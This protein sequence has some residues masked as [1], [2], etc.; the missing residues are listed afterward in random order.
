MIKQTFII[1]LFLLL[2]G[3][4]SCKDD[5]NSKEVRA[6]NVHFGVTASNIFVDFSSRPNDDFIMSKEGWKLS[7]QTFIYDNYGTL[8][9]SADI[10]CSNLTD[11]LFFSPTLQPGEYL[12]LSVADF[13]EGLG[14]QGYRF[15]YISNEDKLQ[16]MVISESSEIYPVA[17]ETLGLE[18]QK[19]TVNKD[20]EVTVNASIKPFTS[21][22]RIH[23]SNSDISG[24][25][26][27]GYSRFTTIV[28]KYN[29]FMSNPKKSVC[30]QDGFFKVVNDDSI[31]EEIICTSEVQSTWLDRLEPNKHTYRALLPNNECLFSWNIKQEEL[32]ADDVLSQFAGKIFTSGECKNKITI[33]SNKQYEMDMILDILELN[34]TE[35]TEHF[36]FEAYHNELI[37]Q[38]YKKSIDEFLCK[39][40]EDLLLCSE[41][42]V[43]DFFNMFP[44][45]WEWT[46]SN[47]LYMAHYPRPGIESFE[48]E[49]TACYSNKKKAHLMMLQFML[50]DLNEV[51]IEYVKEKLS[52]KYRVDTE[53]SDDNNFCYLNPDKSVDSNYRIVFQKYLNGG[54]IYYTLL[55]IL[56][57]PYHPKDDMSDEDSLD[58][59]IPLHEWVSF[60]GASEQDY[61]SKYGD[62][63]D[64]RTE[65]SMSYS[66]INEHV[67]T[68]IIS[69]KNHNIDRINVFLRNNT[70]PI[71][72]YISKFIDENFFT[73]QIPGYFIDSPNYATRKKSILYT[74]NDMIT[75][76]RVNQ[77]N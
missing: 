27:Q 48:I 2:L 28:E 65:E 77:T 19:I 57:A 15:W 23:E 59:L 6:H 5:D 30:I 11:T 24:Y 31:P 10:L 61:I 40:Y 14:G 52:T 70:E 72:N 35:N 1:S 34:V 33:T 26:T 67:R 37:D 17:F 43:N 55:Y 20:S 41:S 44:K 71:Q 39:N 46:S 49:R 68:I 36:D 7:L 9:D 16:D 4:T 50:P 60:V 8:I 66:N 13:R 12:V 56:R 45:E 69:L 42:D 25:G 73:T 51:Q 18:C 3:L 74:G 22:F 53:Y 38:Y 29:I 64:Y 32:S 21:L 62:K 63:Y 75:I 54:K 47:E 58:E 76:T